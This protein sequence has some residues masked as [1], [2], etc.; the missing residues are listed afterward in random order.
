MIETQEQLQKEIQLAQTDWRKEQ[1]HTQYLN[2]YEEIYGVKTPVNLENIFD[3]CKEKPRKVLL[4]GRAGIGKSTLCQ[5]VTYR[6]AKGQLWN[7]YEI[8]IL[9]RLRNLI[10]KR[11]RNRIIDSPVDWV[12]GEYLATD[13]RLSK[14]D[15][16]LLKVKCEQ[17]HVLW[18]LDGYDEFASGCSDQHRDSFEKLR[19]YDHILTS[20][21]Y[22]VKMKYDS[23]AEI[24]GF[25]DDDIPNYVQTFFAHGSNAS[26]SSTTGGPTQSDTLVK[27]L[28]HHPVIHGI[29]HIPLLLEL[30]CIFWANKSTS[31]DQ[32]N[33]TISTLYDNLILRFCQRQWRKRHPNEEESTDK[34]LKQQ[35]STVLR[36]HEELAFEAT[37]SKYIII[38]P[39][40][41]KQII[42]K[43]YEST[44]K[45]ID[46]LQFG[47]IKSFDPRNIP[48]DNQTEHSYYFLHLSFQEYFAACYLFHALKNSNSIKKAQEFVQNHKYDDR[49][50][51]T[52]KFLT[53][54]YADYADDKEKTQ[55]NRFFILIQQEPKDLL[56]LRHAKLLIDIF[57]ETYTHLDNKNQTEFFDIISRWIILTRF[58]K[59]AAVGDALI[60]SLGDKPSLKKYFWI[61]EHLVM[62]LRNYTSNNTKSLTATPKGL[63]PLEIATVLYGGIEGL[64]KALND[65][66][67][68]ARKW[69]CDALGQMGEKAASNK[70]IEAL[71]NALSDESDDVR[72]GACYALGKMG[73]KAA[74][75]IVRSLVMS[76]IDLNGMGRYDAA[77][78]FD[79]AIR[80]FKGSKEWDRTSV[81]FL[82]EFLKANDQVTLRVM[83]RDLF[84]SFFLGDLN[85]YWLGIFTLGVLLQGVAVVLLEDGVISLG[86]DIKVMVSDPRKRSA[87]KRKLEKACEKQRKE[88]EQSFPFSKSTSS[89]CSIL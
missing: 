5:Y 51:F 66:S 89:V 85:D 21:P 67:Q 27:F 17:G 30:L 83:R 8:I 14:D 12:E 79:E 13:E 53:L 9:I 43:Y 38:P 16:K 68:L 50:T 23:K 55:L 74:D 56:G 31:E 7:H 40:N 52:F 59:H 78:A 84:L 54:L 1:S 19:E 2:A 77:N 82:H 29:A 69:A 32:A 75:D 87:V 76:R 39:N 34:Q 45:Y 48:N 60:Q 46:A 58:Y 65:G 70:V 6:W 33:Y 37:E 49:L 81:G 64:V 61:S 42:E 25:I 47:I 86:D 62:S 72:K 80:W 20:R 73:E 24:M 57:G 44:S 35:L 22:A 71:V 10:E 18:I 3:K 63:P 4:C 41:V 11:Y 15:R 36:F 28:H 26:E 88:L